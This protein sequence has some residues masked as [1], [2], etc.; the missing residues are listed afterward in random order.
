MIRSLKNRQVP[1][2]YVVHST[3]QRKIADM[4]AQ[5][6]IFHQLP[7]SIRASIYRCHSNKKK[8]QPNSPDVTHR[9]RITM[10]ANA[11]TTFTSS[12]ILLYQNL[13]QDSGQVVFMANDTEVP[14]EVVQREFRNFLSSWRKNVLVAE[15]MVRRIKFKVQ[16]VDIRVKTSPR[17]SEAPKA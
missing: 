3:G 5:L 12:P 15:D 10:T 16:N 17:K 6:Q 1:I 11:T 2:Q 4:L 13:N 7:L 8:E 14:S 9:K